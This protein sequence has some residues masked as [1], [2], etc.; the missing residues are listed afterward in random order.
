MEACCVKDEYRLAVYQCMTITVYDNSTSTFSNFTIIT[1]MFIAGLR[2]FSRYAD[3]STCHFKRFSIFV[4][5]RDWSVL[6]K[7]LHL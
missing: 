6:S 3:W 2:L 7:Q 4:L 5:Q 1:S